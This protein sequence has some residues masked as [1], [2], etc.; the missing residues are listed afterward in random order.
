MDRTAFFK[1]LTVTDPVLFRD[2]MTAAQRA[3][4]SLKLDIWAQWYAHAHPV[5]HLAAALGQIYRETGGRMEPVLEAFA[6]D[7]ETAAQ[8]L[9]A[10][11][12][13]GRL[14]WVRQPYWERDET[15][16]RPLGGGDIQL[17][18]RRNYV[19]AETRLCNRFGVSIGLSENY[20]LILDPVVS[21][22][23]AFAGMIEGWFRSCKLDDFCSDAGFDYAAARDIVNGDAGV[24]GDEIARNCQ[25][26][27]AALRAA[28]A[29]RAFGPP[30]ADI[31]WPS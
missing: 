23:V 31:D 17:T 12:E 19:A 13:A 18:H 30:E 2:G 9:Q 10:A 15:G 28:G 27:E 22:H 4:L 14:K 1:H 11:W 21:A 20:D 5:S 26:F 25:V 16:R 8:R 7:R 6:P 24:I 29:D 3:G